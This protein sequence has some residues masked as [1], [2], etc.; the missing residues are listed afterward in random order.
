MTSA[1]TSKARQVLEINT[2][3]Q[4]G[5]LIEQSGEENSKLAQLL[6]RLYDHPLPSTRGGV[7]FNTHNYPTKINTSAVVACIMAHT[8]PGDLVFDGFAG[9]GVTGLAA[10]LC[11]KP[12][13]DLRESVEKILGSATWGSRDCVLYDVSELATFISSTVLNPPDADRLSKAA[14]EIL[15]LLDAEW[16]WIYSAKDTEGSTGKIRHTLWTDHPICPH[17]GKASTFWRLAVSLSPPSMKSLVRCEQ[18]LREFDVASAPRLTE[19]YFDDLLGQRLE[20]RVR[21]PAFI[22]GRTGKSLWRR[23]T[24][25]EDLKLIDRINNTS[26]PPGVP[27]VR[28]LEGKEGRWGELYRSGY[29]FGI[30]YLHHFYTRRNLI[31]IAAAWQT[32][33]A[34]PKNICNALR[35]WI[36]SYNAMHSTLM[37]RVV[38]KKGA[39]DFVLTGAQPATLY[40][41]S[42]PVEKNV[43]AGL[44]AKLKPITEAFRTLQN[45]ENKVS[46]NCASSLKVKLPDASVDYIFTDP[47]FGHNIQYSEVS[48]ISEAWLGKATDSI[49]EVIISPYQGKSIQEYQALLSG[50]FAEAHRILKPGRFMTVAFHSTTPSVWNAL[51]AAWELTG[52]KLVRISLLDK[53]QSSFKQ[54]TTRGAVKGDPLILLQKP[55]DAPAAEIKGAEKTTQERD[56]HIRDPWDLITERLALFNGNGNGVKERTRQRLYS[57]FIS[58]YLSQG[59]A[60]PLDAKSFFAGLDKRFRR[61]GE[62]Y[63]VKNNDE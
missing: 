21:T 53:T 2:S 4:S 41:S 59:H 1:N 32:T 28:M 50:A 31:A 58:Y 51:R 42:L 52:F 20:R 45:R 11:D 24:T 5:A 39:K 37:N 40:I 57:Y 63:Y 55:E 14:Q 38:C 43:F 12:D 56:L 34:Y 22:Y 17:C 44:R 3:N 25:K 35:F 7:I 23:A 54:N 15:S 36:S 9:S 29:H 19:S 60:I 62:R 46:I 16:S 30:T 47:P 27:V 6:N 8:K 26:I 49:E 48:F 10:T 13:S 33:A 61:R 18:C